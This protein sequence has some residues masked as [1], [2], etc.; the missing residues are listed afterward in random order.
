MLL[1]ILGNIIDALRYVM[2]TVGRY[3]SYGYAIV[4]CFITLHCA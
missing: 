1:Q 4:M 2:V 3:Q